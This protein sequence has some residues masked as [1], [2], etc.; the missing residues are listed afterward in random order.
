[1]A[2]TPPTIH[3][4]HD[5]LP[6]GLSFSSG[7]VALDTE[8]TGLSL[9]NDRLCL[10]QVGDGEG[11]VWLVKFDVGNPATPPTYAAPNL[12]AVLEHPRLTKLF[13]YARFD[14]AMLQKHLGLADLGPMFCTKLASKLVRP[15]ASKHNLRALVAEYAGVELDKTEQMSNWAAPTLTASQQA[16]AASDVLYLHTLTAKLT[17]QLAEQNLTYAYDQA[18]KFLATRV[19][20]D[21]RGFPETDLFAHH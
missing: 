7:M 5:D 18:L 20:L 11:N 17:E 6:P 21:L 16:Y 8:T 12:R 10:V 3:L 9:V 2:S 19:A 4:V 1:M 14:L 13:H 15:T